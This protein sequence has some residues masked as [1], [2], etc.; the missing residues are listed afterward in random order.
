MN[1]S[2][3]AMRAECQCGQLRV[4]LPGPSA[5]VVACHC[6]ACQRRSGAPFGVLAFYP[7]DQVTISGDARRFDRPTDEGNRFE[8]FFCPHCGSMVYVRAGKHPML[9]GVTVG[10]IADPAF[11][12]PVRSVWEQS[13][14]NWVA[15]P[16]AAQHH[17]KGRG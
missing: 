15:M 8:S 10:A 16:Q 11:P 4:D 5:A 3:K 7:A 2:A 12:A 17:P 1:N 9:I 6:I 13:M 14:H